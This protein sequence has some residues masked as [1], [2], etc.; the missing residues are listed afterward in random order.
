MR[1]AKWLIFLATSCVLACTDGEADIDFCPDDPEKTV[2]GI[3]GCGTPDTINEATGLPFCLETGPDECPD[4]PNKTVPGICGCG[5]PDTIDPATGIPLCLDQCPDDPDKFFPGICGCDTPDTDT[6]GDGVPD[7]FDECPNDPDKIFPGICGCGTPDITTEDADGN[8]TVVCLDMCPDNPDKFAPGVCGCDIPDTADNVRDDDGDGVPNCLDAC[9]NN[10]TKWLSPGAGGCDVLDSDGDGVDDSEDACPYNPNIQTAAQGDCNIVTEGGVN[11]FQIWS[12]HDLLTLKQALENTSKPIAKVVIMR[13]LNLADLDT[14]VI[15]D[16]SACHGTWTPYPLV[17]IE[18]DGKNHAIRFQH[19]HTR[20]HLNNALFSQVESSAIKNLTLNYDLLGAATSTLAAKT[21]ASE[22][23]NIRYLGNLISTSTANVGG[24]VAESNDSKFA[25]VHFTGNLLASR[26]PIVGGIVATATKDSYD[27]IRT[28]IASLTGSGTIGGSFGR[29]TDSSV[30]LADNQVNTIQSTGSGFVG[31]FAS[32]AQNTTL[33]QVRNTV[34]MVSGGNAGGFAGECYGNNTETA[35]MSFIQ[36]RVGTVLGTS[37]TAGLCTNMDSLHLSDIDNS[38]GIVKGSATNY[39]YIG[40]LAAEARSV[41][42]ERLINTIDNIAP[43]YYTAGIVAY[44]RSCSIE[45]TKNHIG[46]IQTTFLTGGVFA[47]ANDITIRNLDNTVDDMQSRNSGGLTGALMG[48]G[49]GYVTIEN[50]NNSGTQMTSVEP[51]WFA[52]GF[53]AYL[54]AYPATIRQVSSIA[55][56]QAENY[57]QIGGLLGINYDTL[58]LSSIFSSALILDSKNNPGSG[59]K[60]CLAES[61]SSSIA[62][63]NVFWQRHGDSDVATNNAT[64]N[65]MFIEAGSP[66]KT[67]DA[68]TSAMSAGDRSWEVTKTDFFDKNNDVVTLKPLSL[69]ISFKPLDF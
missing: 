68:L 49:F 9:P 32:R 60:M 33:T 13:D 19:S 62:A 23:H 4:D 17:K 43:S 28:R 26:A 69:E 59:A 40:G 24:I 8:I 5:V 39:D 30:N 16:G 29:I 22:L 53:V 46:Q 56:I 11:V 37:R 10:P 42:V 58:D 41:K 3:C 27:R 66:E 38:V 36:N 64:F 34:D 2:P 20:C 44:C 35:A 48:A 6:D 54:S 55:T 57:P 12:A 47:E 65:A 25:N 14:T 7:C 52:G 61:Y 21:S 51:V 63:K 67:L 31:G 18:L 15:T 1:N 45:N 50:V